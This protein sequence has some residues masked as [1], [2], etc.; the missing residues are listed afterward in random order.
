MEVVSLCS[1]CFLRTT[2][3]SVA[4]ECLSHN[5]HSC[6]KYEVDAYFSQGGPVALGASALTAELQSAVRSSAMLPALLSP[7]E[8]SDKSKGVRRPLPSRKSFVTGSR[9]G[10]S[11]GSSR[12]QNTADV[13]S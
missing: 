10:S 3:K 7:P 2:A 8:H 9:D 13:Y 1:A 4:S 12:A 6:D 5:F 11:S